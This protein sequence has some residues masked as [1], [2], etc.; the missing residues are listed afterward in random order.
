MANEEKLK[1]LESLYDD[2]VTRFTYNNTIKNGINNLSNLSSQVNSLNFS[3]DVP[4]LN[5]M[6]DQATNSA[7][8]KISDTLDEV[9]EVAEKVDKAI[10]IISNPGK[11]IDGITGKIQE[12]L[13]ASGLIK[14][15]AP[16]ELKE[17]E[18]DLSNLP[19]NDELNQENEA[20]SKLEDAFLSARQNIESA[21]SSIIDGISSTLKTITS[22]G[23]ELYNKASQAIN[24]VVNEV[25]DTL[26]SVVGEALQIYDNI[27]NEINNF[28]KPLVD[29][30]KQ[31][32]QELIDSGETIVTNLNDLLSS[33]NINPD[34]LQVDLNKLG[35]N[36]ESLDYISTLDN[37]IIEQTKPVTDKVSN[38]AN[39]TT[40]LISGLFSSMNNKKTKFDSEAENYVN[41]LDSSEAT[42]RTNSRKY[43]VNPYKTQR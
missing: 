34:T 33:N 19:R 18:P 9:E 3:V 21:S 28:I 15:S 22:K 41:S 35:F 24:S 39:A 10:D 36:Q 23:Q 38:I 12:V 2:L 1:K 43:K 8:D 20:N 16:Q 6:V 27:N 31:L 11:I 5:D 32:E 29:K 37:K 7:K 25:K 26:N 42:N 14:E 17:R 40:N 30:Y 4:S 13:T